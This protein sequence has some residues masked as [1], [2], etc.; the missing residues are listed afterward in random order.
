VC[1]SISLLFQG[2]SQAMCVLA[3]WVPVVSRS[4]GPSPG[5][6]RA[7]KSARLGGVVSPFLGIV[8]E[9]GNT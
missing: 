9:V 4:N 3:L 2:N 7:R 8:C 5:R 6:H 1:Y